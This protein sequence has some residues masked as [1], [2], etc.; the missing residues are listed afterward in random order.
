ML[1]ASAAKLWPEKGLYRDA[2]RDY[3]RLKEDSFGPKKMV[4][5]PTT[6]L[7]QLPPAISFNLLH[8][9]STAA[10]RICYASAKATVRCTCRLTDSHSEPSDSRYWPR[11]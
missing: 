6:M 1:D 3:R 8:I 10:S 9:R 7:D 4:S 11:G 5:Q 2:V